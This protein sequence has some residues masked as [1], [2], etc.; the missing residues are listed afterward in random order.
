MVAGIPVQHQDD[1]DP[2]DGGSAGCGQAWHCCNARAGFKVA[3]RSE[4]TYRS[5]G[6]L[7]EGRSLYIQC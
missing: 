3:A 1:G 6:N 4:C 5:T 2:S 7:I